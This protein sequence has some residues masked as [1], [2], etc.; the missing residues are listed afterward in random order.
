MHSLLWLPHLNWATGTQQQHI[1][2][3]V[4]VRTKMLIVPFH[5][6]EVLPWELC[7]SSVH[8]DSELWYDLT[9]WGRVT[10]ICVSDLTSISSDN[11]LSPGWR[12]AIIRTNA[13]IFLKRPLGTNFS[14][15]L[16]EILK[17][18][19]KKMPFKVLSAKRLPF[20]LSFSALIHCWLYRVSL[21]HGQIISEFSKD[22]TQN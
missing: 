6:G 14:E 5:H 20:C 16:V 9:H 12:Q 11:G 17:F 2:S 18:S 7:A 19:F 21:M 3:C 13:G 15:F 10:H 4:H 22:T 8:G 1:T